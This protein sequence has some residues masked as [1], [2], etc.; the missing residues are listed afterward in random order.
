MA[1][2]S[3]RFPGSRPKWMLTHPQSNEYMALESLKGLNLDFFENIYFVCLQQHQ[4]KYNFLQG[5]REGLSRLGIID[6]VK[7]VFLKSETRSQSE[8]VYQAII[9]ENIQGFIYIKDSDG[10]FECNV[11]DPINQVAYSNLELVESINP[12]SKSYI[13]NDDS[14]F[15]TNIVEKQVVS[16]MFCVGGYG[17]SDSNDFVSTFKLLEKLDREIYVSDIIYRMLLGGHQFTAVETNHFLDWGTSVE[18]NNYKRRFSTLFLDIDGTLISN[19]SIHFEPYLGT[20]TPLAMN[21][22][23]INSLRNSKQAYVVLVTSR[24]DTFRNLTEVELAKWGIE[25]DVLLMGLPHS[26]R[27]LIND[28]SLTNPYPS[29]IAINLRRNSDDLGEYLT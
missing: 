4:E 19:T 5:F 1:G 11:S 7:I 16:S 3:S 24:P 23:L 20:G 12:I 9:S 15:L 18:W 21:I 17:F 28:F 25:Y 10:Y 27:V 13:L 26:R 8:T 22:R 14:D 6:K 29:A 2:K